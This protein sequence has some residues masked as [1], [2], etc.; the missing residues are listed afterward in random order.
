MDR[1]GSS[2]PGRSGSW[3]PEN[4]RPEF[5]SIRPEDARVLLFDG[6]AAP[7]AAF[8]PKLSAKAAQALTGSGVELHMHS[9]VTSVDAGGLDVT[10]A[11]G[12][13]RAL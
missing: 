10:H 6:G 3:P 12:R 1:P 13:R 11:D 2:W 8:G 7:L 9:R 4:L 5:H